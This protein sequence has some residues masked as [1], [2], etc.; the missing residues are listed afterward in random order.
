MSFSNTGVHLANSRKSSSDSTSE[1]CQVC[2]DKGG[3]GRLLN[4]SV[5]GLGKL[6]VTP[7]LP[8]CSPSNKQHPALP[9]L[10]KCCHSLKQ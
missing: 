2:F 3:K 1:M 8:S 6:S 7:S 4:A 10:Q 9:L 5:P